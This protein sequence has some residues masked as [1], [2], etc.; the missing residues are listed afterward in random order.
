MPRIPRKIPFNPFNI[1]KGGPLAKT[2]V[3]ALS[4]GAAAVGFTSGI[5][6]SEYTDQ[7]YELATGNPNIDNE[8][9][10][11]NL[12]LTQLFIPLPGP[13]DLKTFMH[14]APGAGAF[15]GVPRLFAGVRAGVVNTTTVSD[16]F[17]GSGP[18]TSNTRSPMDEFRNTPPRVDGSIVFG[19]YNSRFG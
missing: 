11:S 18:L 14:G 7:F 4:V 2:G 1:G 10:G 8:V 17:R 19:Q 5:S 3:A 13:S 12:G 9:F 6:S 15:G 16:Y